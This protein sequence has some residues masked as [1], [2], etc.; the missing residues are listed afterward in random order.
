MKKER[1]SGFEPDP[2]LWKRDKPPSILIA[3]FKELLEAI[4]GTLE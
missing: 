1:Y 3:Q 4:G 2:S